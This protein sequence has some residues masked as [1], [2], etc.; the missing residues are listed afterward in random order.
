MIVD[1]C[2]SAISKACMQSE[3]YFTSY[4]DVHKG[5]NKEQSR[6]ASMT[7][8]GIINT[9]TRSTIRILSEHTLDYSFPIAVAKN[10]N[11][12]TTYKCMNLLDE[13]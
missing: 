7:I 10:S 3:M 6:Q 11:V 1:E 12:S 13:L 9:Y 2:A 5:K 8:F 4:G